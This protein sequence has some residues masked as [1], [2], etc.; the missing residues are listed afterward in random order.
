MATK[1]LY[2]DNPMQTE[3]TANLTETLRNELGFGVIL[4]ETIFYPTS[5]GQ[6][7]DTGV[8]GAANVVNVVIDDDGRIIHYLDKEIE[9]GSYPAKI[10]WERRFA[11]MQHHTAQHILSAAFWQEME[12]ETL[13]SHI[14]GTTPTTIDFDIDTLTPEQITR[15][16]DVANSIIFENRTVKTYFVS[17]K[18]QVNF[19]RPPKVDGE[20]R[21]IEIEGFDYSACGGTHT[22]QTGMVGTLKI[23]KT[24]RINQKTRIHFV[25][26]WQ[27]LNFLRTTQSAA[28]ATAALLDVGFADMAIT[29]ERMKS[30]LKE[31]ES[32]LK[33][34]RQMKLD[35]EAEQIVQFAE[36]VGEKWLATK[37]FEN[38]DAGE[39]RNLAMRLRQ[40]PMMVALLAS[41]DGKKLSFIAAC[42]DG[43]DL[44][45]SEL[46]RDH[47]APFG[48][49]GGGDRSIAQ[50]GCAVDDISA[51]FKHSKEMVRNS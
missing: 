41:Y 15:V 22:P 28:Q 47:L 30:Q 50:G 20:I 18:S 6:A 7:H 37:V 19:R 29:V 2:F 48:G 21:V 25:A 49:R 14:S 26:G 10:D 24:E 44:N 4:P 45:A 46:L 40:Y 42:A 1:K 38:R 13:S 36:P 51:L 31:A 23:V 5:G 32:E 11:N 3:F 39:L 12:L 9:V 33:S 8:I 17:D 16:E 27:A 43:T 34:L 35:A